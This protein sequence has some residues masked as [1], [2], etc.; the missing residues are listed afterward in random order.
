MALN[1][2]Y[3]LTITA[4]SVVSTDP[5]FT[6]DN[7][8]LGDKFKPLDTWF[9]DASGNQ[10]VYTSKF[11][12]MDDFEA[13]ATKLKK[14]DTKFKGSKQSVQSYLNKTKAFKVGSVLANIGIS[15]LF[16]GYI[17]PNAV[18]AFRE[19]QTGSTKFHVAEDIKNNNKKD[20]A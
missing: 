2:E 14:I 13:L 12:N 20:L 15:C 3:I 11:I 4:D 16:L 19:K 8:G 5:N 10:V 9:E 18:Y 7:L 6:M 17:I 1:E